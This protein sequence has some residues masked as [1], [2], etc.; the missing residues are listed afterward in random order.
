MNTITFPSYFQAL[1]QS[2]ICRDPQGRS[3]FKKSSKVS[4]EFWYSGLVMT[5]AYPPVYA[6]LTTIVARITSS[7][8]IHD[9]LK[10]F[11]MSFLDT[12]CWTVIFSTTEVASWNPS[13]AS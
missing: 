1:I 4:M 3:E 5:L 9:F 7:N 10:Y 12:D 2:D 11:V 8:I 6:M 13:L